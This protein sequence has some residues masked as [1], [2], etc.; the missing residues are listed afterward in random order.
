MLKVFS[1]SAKMEDII[2][3]SKNELI[4]GFTTNPTLMAKSGITDYEYFAKEALY[5]IGKNCPEKSLSLE[6]FADDFAE[7]ERQA[8]LIKSWG[9]ESN[10]QVYVKI[11]VMNTK[12]VDSYELIR[13]LSLQEV[14]MNVTAIFT[15][16]QVR[17]TLNNLNMH[18]PAIIS[19]FAG[20]IADAG[21]DPV[22][23]FRDAIGLRHLNNMPKVEVLWASP[24]E[25]FNL[26][27]AREAGVD[28]IT[29]TPELIGKIA[30]LGKNLREFSRETV[31]MFYN[32]SVKSGFKI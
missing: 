19:I 7:M 23:I 17:H 1:D 16:D 2:R 11:P 13:S 6:V 15:I 18:V 24:R 27:Q 5:Y 3:M 28:I 29:M 21:V 10:A 25:I 12:G 8:L 9:K 22:P 30:G 14:P 26:V 31:E 20:R 32:D 4:T